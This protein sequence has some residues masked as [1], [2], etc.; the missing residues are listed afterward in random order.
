MGMLKDAPKPPRLVISTDSVTGS[1]IDTA[2]LNKTEAQGCTNH[3]PACTA[4]FL[5]RSLNR[6]LTHPQMLSHPKEENT[7]LKMEH[8]GEIYSSVH[9]MVSQDS[10]H[11]HGCPT[12]AAR[13]KRFRTCH[14][15]FNVNC[16]HSQGE[17][18]RKENST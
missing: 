6:G 13:Q 14:H 12:A 4:G 18:C 15:F 2:V 9:W 7:A 1:P 17:A 8:S 10:S 5:Q 11:A 3:H 16:G